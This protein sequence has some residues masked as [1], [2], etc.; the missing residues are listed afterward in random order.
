M[1]KLLTKL[2]VCALALI[3]AVPFAALTG[4]E[5]TETPS[6][7]NK[8]VTGIVFDVEEVSLEVGATQKIE[9]TF[10]PADATDKTL[11]WESDDETVATVTD[12]TIT[13]VAEGVAIITATSANGKTASCGVTV[14]MPRGEA[15]VFTDVV[16]V[17]ATA[18]AAA[19]DNTNT[20]KLYSNGEAE[21]EGYAVPVEGTAYEMAPYTGTFTINKNQFVFGGEIALKMLDAFKFPIKTRQS[22]DESKNLVMELYI[23][24]GTSDFTLGTFILTKEQAAAFG[25]DTTVEVIKVASINWSS[26]IVANENG[27]LTY[28]MVAGDSIDL[29]T[30]VES[31]EPADAAAT[32]FDAVVSDTPR[33]VTVMASTLMANIAGTAKVTASVD[34]VSVTI[35]VTVTYPTEATYTDAVVFE[36]TTV[37]T[38]VTSLGALSTYF[39]A[40][41]QMFDGTN[42]G[43]YT[44]VKESDVVTAIK[45]KT[46]NADAETVQ[47]VEVN[48]DGLITFTVDSFLGALN[49]VEQVYEGGF[50]A[51]KSFK[52]TLYF[53]IGFEFKFAADNTFAL[54]GTMYSAEYETWLT[55]SS[56]TGYYTYVESEEGNT[57]TIVFNDPDNQSVY[58]GTYAVTVDEAG[59]YNI[60]IGIL[61]LTTKVAA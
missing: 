12:G 8:E 56:A 45:Y 59:D 37:F 49:Y 14:T 20:L 34:D 6:G 9:V 22:F 3:I 25:V 57:V 61:N 39:Y 29:N 4:C 13:A 18:D 47:P 54:I 58:G 7:G 23:N 31:F 21:F 17:P 2:M 46:Y 27:E 1:K 35:A 19:F 53:V 44:L 43:E 60:V 52:A 48:E 11:T 5:F 24:N 28:T 55:I 51:E 38:A 40:N 36:K 41:G 32:A 30:L 15:S 16:T 10:I 33:Y 42:V 26:A 50:D